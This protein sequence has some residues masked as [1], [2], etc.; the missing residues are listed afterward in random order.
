MTAWLMWIVL[1]CLSDK[2]VLKCT[3]QPMI[4]ASKLQKVPVSC[5]SLLPGSKQFKYLLLLDDSHVTQITVEKTPESAE[6]PFSGHFEVTASHSGVYTCK[7]EVQYPPPYQEE[8]YSTEIQVAV[9]ATNITTPLP[10]SQS[11]PEMSPFM[12]EVVMYAACGVLLVYSLTV[13][14]IAFMTWRK[15]KKHNEDTSVYMNTRPGNLRKTYK[16]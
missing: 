12:L 11:C 6:I 3:V 10:S 5:P 13:T 8:F 15:M 9:T 2:A 14:C 7:M 16:A 1:A 4:V